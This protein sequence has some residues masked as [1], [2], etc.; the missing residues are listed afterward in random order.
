MQ[1]NQLNFRKK[2]M[3][4][5]FHGL[6]TVVLS[7]ICENPRSRFV[8]EL[9]FLL[10]RFWV[11]K[12]NAW[13]KLFCLFNDE[14][15][16]IQ[17]ILLFFRDFFWR[18]GLLEYWIRSCVRGHCFGCLLRPGTLLNLTCQDVGFICPFI[19]INRLGLRSDYGSCSEIAPG[20]MFDNFL[21]VPDCPSF[22][23][24]TFR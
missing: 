24:D 8:L 14:S 1:F 5:G 19:V 15:L 18:S 23:I 13:S 4:N 21:P 7:L 12:H 16:M 9:M 6:G 10:C 20:L 3:I 11:L 2:I 22:D 17:A